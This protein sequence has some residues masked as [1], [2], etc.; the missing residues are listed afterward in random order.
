MESL[1]NAPPQNILNMEN[2]VPSAEAKKEA[3]S[4][5]FT[6]GVGT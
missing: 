2:N 5:P 1:S 6:P 4:A 3:N